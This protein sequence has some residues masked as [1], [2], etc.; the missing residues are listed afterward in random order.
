MYGAGLIVMVEAATNT[1]VTQRQ[2]QFVSVLGWFATIAGGVSIPVRLIQLFTFEGGY[3]VL[4][5]YLAAAILLTCVGV[6]LVRRTSW[7]LPLG[8]VFLALGVVRQAV[9]LAVVIFGEVPLPVGVDAGQARA[10]LGGVYT[11]SLIWI[12]TYAPD[13]SSSVA[14]ATPSSE[15]APQQAAAPG[16]GRERSNNRKVRDGRRG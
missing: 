15:R 2:S 1:S 8:A 16:G 13:A 14:S 6:G 4:G 11:L 3:L 12:T 5:A 7:A 10:V 9:G